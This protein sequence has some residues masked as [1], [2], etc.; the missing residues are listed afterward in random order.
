MSPTLWNVPGAPVAPTPAPAPEPTGATVPGTV[1]P[2][3]PNSFSFLSIGGRRKTK[4]NNK[5]SHKQGK[6]KKQNKSRRFFKGFM[7]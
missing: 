4:R 5:K 1:V 7:Y 3:K 6:S 2:Q